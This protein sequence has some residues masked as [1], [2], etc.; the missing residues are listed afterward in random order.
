MERAMSDFK[1]KL[2]NLKELASMSTKF[3][4]DMKKSVCEIV[5]HYKENRVEEAAAETNKEAVKKAKAKDTEKSSS[6]TESSA[7]KK[8]NTDDNK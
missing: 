1:S 8:S 5:Q 2:P 3:Y 7:D 6:T 4:K